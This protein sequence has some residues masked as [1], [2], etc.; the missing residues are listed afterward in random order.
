MLIGMNALH[1]TQV[2]VIDGQV[3]A[4]V[5]HAWLLPPAGAAAIAADVGQTPEQIARAAGWQELRI[6]DARLDV[7]TS[8]IRS[9]RSTVPVEQNEPQEQEPGGSVDPSLVFAIAGAVI[10]VV[11]SARR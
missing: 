3:H 4:R 8:A 1:L 7:P 6:A 11:A 2:E 9:A 5:V 10:D